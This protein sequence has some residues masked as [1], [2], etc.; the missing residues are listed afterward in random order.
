MFLISVRVRKPSSPAGR[1]ETLASTRRVPLHLGVGDPELDD[2]LAEQ[3]QEA[4]GLLGGV[5]VRVRDDL[6]ERGA[7][8]VEVDDGVARAAD[9]AR[10]AAVVDGLGRVLLEV[11]PHDPHGVLSVGSRH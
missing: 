4:P 10:V 6:D 5:D 11:S 9:P 2:R 3:L 7:A 1:T 8:A